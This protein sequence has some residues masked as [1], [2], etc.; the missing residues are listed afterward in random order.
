MVGWV[1]KGMKSFLGEREVSEMDFYWR[2]DGVEGQ[3]HPREVGLLGICEREAGHPLEIGNS[4]LLGAL[5]VIGILARALKGLVV[6]PLIGGAGVMG[7]LSAVVAVVGMVMLTRG[8]NLV[9]VK[10]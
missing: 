1:G 8:K 6:I 3:F 2:Q 7:E 10:L 4:S 9:S 5:G